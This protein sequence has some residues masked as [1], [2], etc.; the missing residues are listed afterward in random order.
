MSG[1]ITPRLAATALREL[2][3]RQVSYYLWYQA[4]LRCGALRWRTRQP[5]LAA[6]RFR[7]EIE[8]DA[9]PPLPNPEALR[10]LLGQ[11]GMRQLIEQAQ[12][13]CAGKAR[14]F[15]TIP[16]QLDFEPATPLAHWTDYALGRKPLP[17]EDIKLLW[18]PARFGWAVTLARAYHASRDEEYVEAFWRWTKRFVQAN[19]PYLGLHWLSAQEAAI[20]L[21]ILAFCYQV[22]RLSP[23]TTPE[24][25]TWLAQVIAAHA[26]RI[27]PTL[28]Y[29]RSQNN[30]HLISEAAALFTAG[31]ILPAHPRAAHWSALGRRWLRYALLSQIAPDGTYVQHSVNYH[32]LL[33]Q[34]ALWV[35]RLTDKENPTHA[36]QVRARLAAATRWLAALLDP[37]SGR[38]PNL[39]PNDGAY[40]LPLT[41]CPSDDYRPVYEAA[42]CAFL[43][44]GFPSFSPT[45]EMRLWLCAQSAEP[46]WFGVA[47]RLTEDAAAMPTPHRLELAGHNSWAYFR[48]AQFHSRPGHADQLHVDLWW[49]GINLAQD[50]G[51]YLYNA[52]PPWD[53]SLARTA[54]HNTVMVD[55]Q[56]QMRRVG[57]FL[58]LEQAQAAL[59]EHQLA[60]D[61]AWERLVARHDG[62]RRLGVVHQRAVL[63]HREG[64][65]E[66]EDLLQSSQ[67]QSI[68]S[69]RLARLHWLLPDYPWEIEITDGKINI[70]LDTPQGHVCLAVQADQGSHQPLPGSARIYRAGELLYGEGEASPILG[71]ISR[72]YAHKI[73]ALSLVYEIRHH[74]PLRFLSTW[75]LPCTSC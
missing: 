14:L 65:W 74:L 67:R 46:R 37:G 35:S 53:N 2:G 22:F 41:N 71:W 17:T 16:A 4:L 20:R 12:E 69:V 23:R 63:A 11:E 43:D 8:T 56:D 32:R 42:A 15:G 52:P 58:W 72:T 26:E 38:V 48:L 57:R 40:L 54:V 21:I 6:T 18:E 36:P 39:G 13:I 50:A 51:S 66:I 27:P 29:A 33:L 7:S 10:D 30:N 3:F 9:L 49:R 62:Y 60:E 31:L 64:R 5:S 24:R 75:T 28:A 45:S 70:R 1:R 44:Q 34:L 47:S 61:G 68:S 19:P 25:S 59:I 73:P 55:D